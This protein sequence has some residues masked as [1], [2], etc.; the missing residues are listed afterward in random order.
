MFVFSLAKQTIAH[1]IFRPQKALNKEINIERTSKGDR[2]EVQNF[3]T[4]LLKKERFSFRFVAFRLCGNGF[5]ENGKKY[6]F[7][8]KNGYL[9]I[10]K[11]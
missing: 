5:G 10:F 4:E 3:C 11:K 1:R 8:R 7:S 6:N 2:E 9:L